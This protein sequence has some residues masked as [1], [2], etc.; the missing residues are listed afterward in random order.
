MRTAWNCAQCD[1]TTRQSLPSSAAMVLKNINRANAESWWVLPAKLTNQSR[2][3]APKQSMNRS[4]AAV[5]SVNEMV[6]FF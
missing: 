1:D 4:A 3:L 6:I 5:Y 2:L